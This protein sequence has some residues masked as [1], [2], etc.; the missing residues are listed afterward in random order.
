MITPVFVEPAGGCDDPLIPKTYVVALDRASL[1]AAF[2]LRLP[3]SEV[4]G[5]DEQRLLVDLSGDAAPTGDL[6]TVWAQEPSPSAEGMAALVL[7]TVQYDAGN[8]CFLLD[9]GELSY[10][11][12]WPAG[13]VGTAEGPGVVLPDGHIA[14]V[15]DE[16]RGG[17]GYLDVADQFGIPAACR[18]SPSEVAVFNPNEDVEV[19]PPPEVPDPEPTCAEIEAFADQLVD[20]GIRYDYQPSASPE[21]LFADSDLVLFG[22]LTGGFDVRPGEP[23]GF[24]GYEV[25]VSVIYKGPP[26]ADITD[27]LT[28]W[29]PV[30]AIADDGATFRDAIATGASVIAFAD[31][32]PTVGFVASIEGL[33]T[34]CGGGP[35]LGFVGT[36][37]DWADVETFGD[38]AVRL[39]LL[40]G[41]S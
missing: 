29:V 33:A 19:N 11:V 34:G 18:L 14:R 10:P 23:Y 35:P 30:G 39:E 6:P 7:G 9:Q 13:T 21:A 40:M 32:D 31:L 38:L 41:Q 26:G 27:P 8:G 22:T 15:G 5:Y 28:I 25:D 4:Y 24:V 1:G 16:V 12:V 36:A 17:G 20:T 2:T 37:G 3:A